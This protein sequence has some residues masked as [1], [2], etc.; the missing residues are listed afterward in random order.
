MRQRAVGCVLMLGGLA[1]AA[2]AQDP[3]NTKIS[4]SVNPLPVGSCSSVSIAL[5]DSMGKDIPRNPAGWRVSLADFDMAV[6]SEAPGAMAGVYNGA[7]SFS[8]CGVRGRR[9]ARPRRSPLRIQRARWLW[10]R[11]CRAYRIRPRRR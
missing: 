5:L 3:W 2:G 7:N 9:P 11:E 4:S 1:V 6:A 10:R 8:V